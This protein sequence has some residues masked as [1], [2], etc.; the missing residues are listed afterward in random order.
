MPLVDSTILE[1]VD[2]D[3]LQFTSTKLTSYSVDRRR[4]YN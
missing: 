2:D 1:E 3:V 4:K